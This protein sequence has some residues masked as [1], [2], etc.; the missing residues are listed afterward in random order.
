M[1]AMKI[2]LLYVACDLYLRW[3]NAKQYKPL[4]KS[5]KAIRKCDA[6]IREIKAASGL[7][8]GIPFKL[9]LNGNCVSFLRV[10]PA[11]AAPGLY[12]E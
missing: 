3:S 8:V 9:S 10:G 7:C 1:S 12:C 5:H 4:S 2:M 6:Q 11:E